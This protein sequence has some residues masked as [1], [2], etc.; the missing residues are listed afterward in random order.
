MRVHAELPQLRWP[1]ADEVRRLRW[2]LGAGALVL[3]TLIGWAALRDV[4]ARLTPSGALEPFS[5]LGADLGAGI[6]TGPRPGDLHDLSAYA[7]EP[8]EVAGPGAGASRPA[9]VKPVKGA[10]A[11]PDVPTI[12]SRR[13]AGMSEP[14]VPRS[15]RPPRRPG[16]R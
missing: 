2:V 12:G 16:A 9:A 11:M 10:P 3:A 5:A 7:H 13:R 8:F 6:P 15:P 1:D 14:R 4:A